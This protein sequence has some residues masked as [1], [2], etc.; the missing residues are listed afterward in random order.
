M[1]VLA[2][3]GCLD[4]FGVPFYAQLMDCPN[5]S[6]PLARFLTILACCFLLAAALAAAPDAGAA[7]LIDGSFD[8]DGKERTYVLVVPEAMEA[9]AREEGPEEG[10]VGTVAEPVPLV[11]LFHGSG[12]DGRSQSV[13]WR[14]LA[15]EEGFLAVAPDSLESEYWEMPTD[16]PDVIRDLVRHLE[17][18]YPVDDRRIYLFGHSGGAS[19]ALKLALFES[20]YFAAAAIHAGALRH[21]T[22]KWVPAKALRPIPLYLT[23]G[24]E[25]PFFPLTEVRTTHE[26]LVAAELP[27]ELVEIPKHDHDYYARSKQVNK[28]AWEFLSAQELDAAPKWKRY[29][30]Q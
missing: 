27:A 20:Q 22:D 9:P 28:A 6:R 12:R 11:I 8:A 17:E 3:R 16:G 23:V 1:A 13:E 4:P 30:F 15:E 19:F 18:S 24:T 21:G 14:R 29:R 7:E 25:D 2:G 10:D 26:A 5:P